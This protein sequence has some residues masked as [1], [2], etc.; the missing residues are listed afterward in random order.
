MVEEIQDAFLEKIPVDESSK[1]WV[2]LK[3]FPTSMNIV[4]RTASRALI[5]APLC[6][7]E[8]YLNFC[9]TYAIDVFLS[10]QIIGLFPRFMMG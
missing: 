5:G 3:I 1:E 9:T 8:T 10:A 2:I 6:R 4:A 7:N